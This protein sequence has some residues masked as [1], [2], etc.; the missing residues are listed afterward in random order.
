MASPACPEIGRPALVPVLLPR[1]SSVRIVS[2]RRCRI[3]WQAG[4]R[5]ASLPFSLPKLSLIRQYSLL[6]SMVALAR[7]GNHMLVPGLPQIS[8]LLAHRAGLAVL[9]GIYPQQGLQLAFLRV[10]CRSSKKDIAKIAHIR[11]FISWS[12]CPS[13]NA[14]TTSSPR[15]QHELRNTTTSVIQQRW[16]HEIRSCSCQQFCLQLLCQPERRLDQSIGS[17]REET[18]PEQDRATKLP[19]EAQEAS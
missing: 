7:H 3:H 4:Q 11:P 12:S 16:P 17:G 18:Y 10:H 19:Q 5:S 15:R 13:F 9:A 1:V 14:N 2:P 8:T 6:V